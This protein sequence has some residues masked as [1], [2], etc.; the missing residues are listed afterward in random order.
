MNNKLDMYQNMGISREVYEYGESI[1]ALLKD[2]FDEIDENAEVNQMKVLKALQD[3]RA[4]EA[5]LMGT[6]G[7]GYNDMGRDILEAVSGKR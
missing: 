5:C 6:T 3:N 7:Y 1:I 2:R 4:S